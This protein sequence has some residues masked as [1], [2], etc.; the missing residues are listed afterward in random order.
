MNRLIVTLLLILNQ[1][2]SVVVASE[3]EVLPQNKGDM[4]CDPEQF[5]EVVEEVKNGNSN[6]EFLLGKYYYW[7]VCVKKDVSQSFLFFYKAAQEGHVQ[8]YYNVAL[9]YDLGIGVP[10]DKKQSAQMLESLLGIKYP[11][12]ID[13][14]CTMSNDYDIDVTKWEAQFDFSCKNHRGQTKDK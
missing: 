4:N 10:V 9:M 2:L 14:V 8:A 6:A 7:G 12:A 5:Q 13:Y 3:Q 1:G 11:K